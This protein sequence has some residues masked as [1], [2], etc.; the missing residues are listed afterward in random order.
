MLVCPCLLVCVPVIEHLIAAVMYPHYA[1]IPWP[2]HLA[3]WSSPGGLGCLGFPF[4]PLLHIPI[5]WPSGC[6][7]PVPQPAFRVKCW[8]V[9]LTNNYGLVMWTEHTKSL[10]FKSTHSWRLCSDLFLNIWIFIMSVSD[11]LLEGVF[12]A[13]NWGIFTE[14]SESSEGPVIA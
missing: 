4:S 10:L 6:K 13:I 12:G 14:T 11:F 2:S 5:L 3:Y 7:S 8:V 1:P 9:L